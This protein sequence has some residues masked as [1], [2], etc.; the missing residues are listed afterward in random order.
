MKVLLVIV[1]TLVGLVAGAFVVGELLGID[2]REGN[3]GI[4]AVFV[5]APIGAIAGLMA[6]L[7]VAIRHGENRR[8]LGRM[9][10]GTV[11]GVAA[12]VLGAFAFET[13]RTWDD[14]DEWGSTYSLSFQ[15]R[16]P[17][18]APSPAGEKFG[19]QLFSDKENP[20][21]KAFDYPHGL[22]QEGGRFLVSAE[23][24]LRYAAKDRTIGVA[25][26]N[27]PTRYFKV[28]VAA[29]PQSASYSQWYPVDQVK[30]GPGTEF[31]SPKPDE[32][33]EI[34]YGAR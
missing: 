11:A 30:D 8:A 19:I 34:R 29:R 27:G 13:W 12:I 31:R 15:V 22:T 20:E 6:G 17:A 18:G 3:A 25:I 33:Y 32:I 26:G 24:T 23:C 21:C 14:I 16:L 5:G 1:W 7:A 2:A 4:F 28:K 9:L 10:A